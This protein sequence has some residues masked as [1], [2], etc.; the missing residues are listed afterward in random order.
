MKWRRL[1]IN[2]R[3]SYAV[4]AL[5][6]LK[7]P[8]NVN[9]SKRILPALKV[10]YPRRSPRPLV[11][12][13]LP[14]DLGLRCQWHLR[15]RLLRHPVL[16]LLPTLRPINPLS[17]GPRLRLGLL[18]LLAAPPLVPLLLGRTPPPPSMAAVLHRKCSDPNPPMRRKNA[19]INVGSLLL[20]L[21]T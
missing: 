18:R 15:P 17:L 21:L 19:F 6:S 8:K 1:T 3:L 4:C 11:S 10:R 16:R 20:L 12:L 9:L 7:N 5:S 13:R 2:S 14:C